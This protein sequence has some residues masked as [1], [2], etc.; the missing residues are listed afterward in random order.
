M[1]GSLQPHRLQHARSPCPSPIPE[2]CSNS[3]PS[4][5]WCHPT[6][7]S[8]AVPFSSCFQSFPASG[9]FPMS[10]LVKIFVS[11]G[12]N[13]GA[14]VSASVF[15]MNV[16]DWFPLG[17]TCLI[18]LQLSKG[19]S[20]LFSNTIVQILQCSTF[21]TVQLSHPYMTTGKKIALII[22]TFVGKV[23]SL[24]FHMLSRFVTAFLPRSIF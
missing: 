17:L 15:P 20:S 16:Q 22:W 13:I 12:Q 8:S 18:S 1:S 21:Y 6:V 24:L 2:A 7:S 11:G 10:Q 9:S 14:S 5:R 19:L 3:C 4:S 23:M